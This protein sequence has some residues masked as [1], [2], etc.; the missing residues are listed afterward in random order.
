MLLIS[1]FG[2]CQ[3]PAFSQFSSVPLYY[4]PAFA[5]SAEISRLS[6]S[7]RNQWDN[8]YQ[9]GILSYDQAVKKLHGGV[10]LLVYNDNVGQGSF[11]TFYSGLVYSAKFNLTKKIGFSCGIKAGYLRESLDLNKINDFALNHGYA[12]ITTSNEHFKP[13]N[14]ADVSAGVLFNTEKGYISFAADHITQPDMSIT[15]GGTAR[16]PVKYVIQSGYTFQKKDSAN[17]SLSLNGIYEFGAQSQ[18]LEISLVGRY[19]WVMLGAAWGNG[20][21]GLVGYY[22]RKF[23][24][25]Y[26]LDYYYFQYFS[27]GPFRFANEISMK[28][29]FKL[30]R[31]NK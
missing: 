1:S 5:G 24:V 2:N 13:A 22:N 10:G 20:I 14:A 16:L 23:V 26:S 3:G 9:S 7:Y 30:K 27:S 28:Y 4:N 18:R 11:K 15:Q 12:N 29:F 19:K 31:K 17:F 21:T 8:I 6:F 25:G